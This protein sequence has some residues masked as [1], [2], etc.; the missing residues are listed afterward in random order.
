MHRNEIKDAIQTS[1]P[2]DSIERQRHQNVSLTMKKKIVIARHIKS[3]MTTNK[4][5]KFKNDK[6]ALHELIDFIQDLRP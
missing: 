6:I 3:K 5:R 4:Y 2:I 1:D